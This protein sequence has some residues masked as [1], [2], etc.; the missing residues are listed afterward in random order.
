MSTRTLRGAAAIVGAADAGL[1]LAVV[2]MRV[3]LAGEPLSDGRHL[4]TFR[5]A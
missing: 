4:P 2:G 3:V 1:T 5:P